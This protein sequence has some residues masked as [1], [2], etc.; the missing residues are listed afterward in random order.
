MI[1]F[2]IIQ[3]P[4]GDFVDTYIFYMVSGGGGPNSV[5]SPELEALGET[6][7]EQCGLNRPIYVQ[8]SN[9][10]GSFSTPTSACP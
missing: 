7:R 5:G 10:R 3:L 4:P 1:S 9:G 8:Y 6:L 2:F